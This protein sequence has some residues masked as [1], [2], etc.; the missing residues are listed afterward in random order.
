MPRQTELRNGGHATLDF[1]SEN[2]KTSPKFT[3]AEFASQRSSSAGKREKRKK[4][5]KKPPI[6]RFRSSQI[7]ASGE[8]RNL[9]SRFRRR[10]S[11]RKKEREGKSI[12]QVR[13]ALSR[14]RQATCYSDERDARTD[15]GGIKARW[16]SRGRS[17]ES[18]RE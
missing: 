6:T 8:S 18:A 5:K 9:H 1:A 12:V 14:R 17:S 13:R 2:V 10:K 15:G 16:K 11:E 4:K 3:S 7:A